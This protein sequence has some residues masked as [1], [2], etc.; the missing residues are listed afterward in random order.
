MS[1]MIDLN[2][3]HKKMFL[4]RKIES[5]ERWDRLIDSFRCNIYM[6]IYPDGGNKTTTWK[7]F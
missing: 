2:Q 5:N 6:N 3:E 4:I 7:K 1:G